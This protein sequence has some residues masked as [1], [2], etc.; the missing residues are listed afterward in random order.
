MSI[1]RESDICQIGQGWVSEWDILVLAYFVAQILE[2]IEHSIYRMVYWT[3]DFTR[4]LYFRV[5][6]IEFSLHTKFQ[7]HRTSFDK[8][9]IINVIGVNFQ[10]IDHFWT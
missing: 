2:H 8:S 5:L 10:Y 7:V 9:C 1:S 6:H 4:D 3:L